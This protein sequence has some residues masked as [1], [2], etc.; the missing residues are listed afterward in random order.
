MLQ[1]YLC[2]LTINTNERIDFNYL[3]KFD[4]FKI[5]SFKLR[6]IMITFYDII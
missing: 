3:M 6:Y 5:Y 1:H 4:F 2:D